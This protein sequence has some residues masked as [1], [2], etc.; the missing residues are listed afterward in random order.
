MHFFFRLI[1][2]KCFQNTIF[3]KSYLH[4]ITNVMTKTIE[5]IQIMNKTKKHTMTKEKVII[6]E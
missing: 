1:F 2:V 6:R 5:N 4:A 3:I